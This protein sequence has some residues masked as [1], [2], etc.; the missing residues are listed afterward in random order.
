MTNVI[1]F[2]ITLKPLSNLDKLRLDELAI[3]PRSV[4]SSVN[5][6]GITFFVIGYY[7]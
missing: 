5:Q 2:I 6:G 4:I 3:T 7:V 1:A